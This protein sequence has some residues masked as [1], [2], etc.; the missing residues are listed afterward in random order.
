MSFDTELTPTPP[1]P[2]RV[3]PPPPRPLPGP[4]DKPDA[5]AWKPTAKEKVSLLRALA[6]AGIIL[7]GLAIIGVIAYA[8]V[9]VFDLYGVSP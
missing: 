6:Q 3:A 7:I 4:L 8:T 5:E 2:K 1:K 9:W